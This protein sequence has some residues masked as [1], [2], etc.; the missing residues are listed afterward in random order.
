MMASYGFVYLIGHDYMPGIYKI[1]Y[2]D[3][4]P[5]QRVQELSASTS[6]PCGFNL[7]IYGEFENPAGIEAALHRDLADMRVDKNREF[8]KMD[9]IFILSRMVNFFDEYA[10]NVT[11]CEA[12]EL[13]I[14]FYEKEKPKPALS[15][16]SDITSEERVQD[17]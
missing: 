13:M 8:F 1:G 17:A 14:I 6:I 12:L 15:L 9:E 10:I 7:I 3:R 2:T 16:V 4:S 5:L 11:R